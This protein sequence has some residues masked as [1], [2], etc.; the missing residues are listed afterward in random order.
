MK[1]DVDLIR[2]IL[3]NIEHRGAAC[4]LEAFRAD[5]RHESDE[6]VRCH[7][8]LAID[9]GWVAEVDRSAV[10][11]QGVRLTHAGHEFIEVARGDARWR[12]AKAVVIEETGGQSLAMLHSLLTK[13]AWR[14][15][16]HGERPLRPRRRYHRY[17]ESAAPVW[18]DSAYIPAPA[19]QD[20][21]Q[22][23]LVRRRR[24]RGRVRPR[25][26]WSHDIYEGLADELDGRQH[27]V[28]LP[29][30]VI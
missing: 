26:D 5:L 8:Q 19:A 14:S 10:G 21:E 16:A 11:L 13:W 17:V 6:R 24:F 30:H 20:D 7:L 18:W 29:P 23:R 15:I 4:P 28:T 25:H 27:S 9:A 22:V 1:R 12:A 3:L 2:Q